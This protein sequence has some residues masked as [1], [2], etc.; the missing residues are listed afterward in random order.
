[1]L[2]LAGCATLNVSSYIERGVDF[3]QFRTYNW[4]PPDTVSTGD[5][6]LDNNPFFH[7]RVY[8]AVEK[9]LAARRFEKITTGTPDLLVH[10]HP[11]MNQRVE[12][13]ALD[14]GYAYCSADDCRPS[15]YEAGT[16]VLDFVDPRTNKVVWRGWAEGSMDGVV[17]NQDV[18]D[19][20][21][22]KAVAQIL[23]RLP[24]R[25]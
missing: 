17:E 15:V 13:S 18:M 5:P 12:A 4:G 25:L 8:A 21:L 24:R 2:V 14:Q 1:V 6:R 7:E 22:D 9:E 3:A 19:A 10:F 23:E 20:K 16:L 11:S